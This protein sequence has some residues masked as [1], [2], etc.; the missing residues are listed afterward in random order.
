LR[1]ALI[2]QMYAAGRACNALLLL[3]LLLLLRDFRQG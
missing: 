3:L 1:R 2:W